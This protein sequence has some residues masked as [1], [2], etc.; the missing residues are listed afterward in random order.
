VRDH[1]VRSGGARDLAEPLL[2]EPEEPSATI[3]EFK[4]E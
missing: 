2:S 3:G 4:L 1:L